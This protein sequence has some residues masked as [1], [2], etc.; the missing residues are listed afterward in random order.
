MIMKLI[1]AEGLR[2]SQPDKRAIHIDQATFQKDEHGKHV[3]TMPYNAHA[4]D[5]V[6]HGYLAYLACKNGEFGEIKPYVEP[7]P[8]EDEADNG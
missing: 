2:Y 8:I 4:D 3:E 1:K 6:T 7:D 5:P